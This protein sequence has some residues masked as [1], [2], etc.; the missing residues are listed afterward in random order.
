MKNNQYP[1]DLMLVADI[2]KNHWHNNSEIRKN[3]LK[4][5]KHKNPKRQNKSGKKEEKATEEEY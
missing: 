3:Y 2:M 5:P 4:T 1:K